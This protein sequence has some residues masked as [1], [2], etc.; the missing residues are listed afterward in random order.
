MARNAVSPA[1][2]PARPASPDAAALG[3]RVRHLRK[4]AGLTLDQASSACG[5]SRAALSRIERGEMS[6]TYDSLCK[7]ATGYGVDLAMLVSGRR[8][9][10][11]AVAVTRAGGG[12]VQETERFIHRL[13]APDYA[14]RILNA[15]ET[16]VRTTSL[17]DYGQ[18]D[19]HDSED[20]YYMLEGTITVH[21]DGHDPVTLRPGDSLQVDGRI[22][23]ALVR[24]GPPPA[25]LLWISTAVPG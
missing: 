3:R 14:G 24:V 22:A 25:R 12:A 5:L 9:A 21:L 23:H 13:L 18:W 7:L 20:V 17:A 10:E 15:F 16:E 4:E 6:P 2:N 8:P 1:E 11:G 19:R